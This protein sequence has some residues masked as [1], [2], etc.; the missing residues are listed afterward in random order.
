MGYM[1]A[2]AETGEIEEY[3][4]L[5]ITSEKRF[6]YM[7]PVLR[8]MILCYLLWKRNYQIIDLLPLRYFRSQFIGVLVSGAAMTRLV[9]MRKTCF[10][11]GYG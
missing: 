4:L 1:R 7:E 2:R 5:A 3:K 8:N 10:S 6:H 9:H 11:C